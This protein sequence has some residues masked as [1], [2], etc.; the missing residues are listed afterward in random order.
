MRG[1]GRGGAMLHLLN[2][3]QSGEKSSEEGYNWGGSREAETWARWAQT[4]TPTTSHVSEGPGTEKGS[5]RTRSP[6][7]RV[8]LNALFRCSLDLS[9]KAHSCATPQ[10]EEMILYMP[11][12]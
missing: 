7:T 5:V 4:C 1:G 8:M 11:P 3:Q 6:I 9:I 2:C 12:V 10:L